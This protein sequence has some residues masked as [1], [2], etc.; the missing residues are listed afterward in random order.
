MG[1]DWSNRAPR[2]ALD[3]SAV[4]AAA[5][6]QAPLSPTAL[7]QSCAR[8]IEATNR[9]VNAIVT[10]D[11][12]TAHKR[13]A[14]I[15]KALMRGGDR[16]T[17]RA[18][19]RRERSPGNGRAQDDERVA[20][21]QGP[22]SGAGRVKRRQRPQRRGLILARRIRPNLAPAATRSIASTDLLAILSM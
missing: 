14:A 22:C 1:P 5:D 12:D 21:L 3:L 15:E 6:R 2:R 16:G 7:L 20:A 8:R 11:L 13:A 9:F 17:G 4:S 18:T 19:D 10:I